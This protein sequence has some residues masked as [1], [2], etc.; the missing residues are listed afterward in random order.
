[1][2]F[3]YIIYALPLLLLFFKERLVGPFVVEVAI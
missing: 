3:L 2:V 1:M